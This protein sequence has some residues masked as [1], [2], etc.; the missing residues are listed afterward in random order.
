MRTPASL[1][2]KSPLIPKPKTKPKLK[3]SQIFYKLK[4][5]RKKY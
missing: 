2:P 3:L 1:T 5:M 4:S